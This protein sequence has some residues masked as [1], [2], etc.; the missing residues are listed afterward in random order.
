MQYPDVLPLISLLGP[1]QVGV[2][3]LKMN[4]FHIY[5]NRSDIKR[6]PLL[7]VRPDETLE[8]LPLSAKEHN[9]VF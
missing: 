4:P 9:Y 5:V 7:I 1:P 2:L 8:N 3:P 6:V